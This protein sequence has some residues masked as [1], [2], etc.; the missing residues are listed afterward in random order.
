M[1]CLVK[2]RAEQDILLFNY[3]SKA[4]PPP[5]KPSMD[6]LVLKATDRQSKSTSN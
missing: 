5:F 1:I 3:Y 6:L 2:L 4:A